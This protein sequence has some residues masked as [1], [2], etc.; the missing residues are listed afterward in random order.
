[1]DAILML[2]EFLGAILV[3]GLLSTAWGV[4][5]RESMTDDHRR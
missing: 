2:L 3:L 4:D 1:M 5:S